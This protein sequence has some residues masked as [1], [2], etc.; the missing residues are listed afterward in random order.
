MNPCEQS[1]TD[2]AAALA[3]GK[4]TS[5]Q[6]VET[7]L[8]R[9]AVLDD[10][11]QAFIT[12]AADAAL[13]EADQKDAA[14]RQQGATGILHGL[15]V[16]VKDN[17]RTAGIR[18]T[19]GSLLRRD[20]VPERDD[21]AVRRLRAAGAIVIGKT[22]TP[23][24]AFGAVCTNKLRGPTANPWNTQLTSGGSSGGSAVAVAAGMAPLAL[25]TDFGGSV[26]TPA[27]FCGCVG[28]RPTPGRIADTD[29]ALGWNALSTAG[30]LARH[31]D[32]AALMLSALSGHHD[33]DPTSFAPSQA[34]EARPAAQLRIAVSP[35]L[36]DAFRIDADVRAAFD[37]ASA[38][39]AQIFAQVTQ[40]APD[41]AGA[42]E[43]FRTLRAA[44]SWRGFGSTVEQSADQLTESFVWNVRA[45]RDISADD[46]LKAE[47]ARTR[48]YRAAARFF[49]D[50]DILV[51]PSAS[52]LPFPNEQMEVTRVGGQGCETII[53]YL[54]CTY[55]IS[56]IGF[57]AMSIPALWT[58]D[59]KPFGIQLVARPYDENT[60]FAAARHLEAAG[61][62]YR[63]P[64]LAQEV[65]T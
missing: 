2:L 17:I 31:T 16:A 55:L 18:T 47:E 51:L 6:A 36:N 54:A 39:I 41:M 5:R 13:A 42:T 11:L 27:S 26:R 25:G 35:T 20:T 65:L 60:L 21:E 4:I 52:V 58:A 63:V 24:F 19:W 53:D 50:H 46:Y 49:R 61:F 22:N 23:E 45:G 34:Q 33:Q 38:R 14:F 3:R 40:A 15:V 48:T 10:S 64:P 7:A 44:N 8:A 37:E 57:P 43:A 30:I 62:C 28:L 1:A 59:G 32:D 29:R 56:L 12:V 9:I